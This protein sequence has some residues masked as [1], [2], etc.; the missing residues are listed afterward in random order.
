VNGRTYY[1]A[2]KARQQQISRK[3][4]VAREKIANKR[5]YRQEDDA[6]GRYPAKIATFPFSGKPS[7]S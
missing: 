7:P 6:L 2:Q 4:D 1:H 5:P 3:L